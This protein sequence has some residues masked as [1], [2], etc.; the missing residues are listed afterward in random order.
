MEADVKAPVVNI[1][2]IRPKPGRLEAFMA[3]QLDQHR[4]VRGKVAGLRGAR[5][6]RSEQG[7]VLISVFD[8]AEQADAF[9]RDPMF[10]DHIARVRPLIETSE[11]GAFTEAY[12][13]GEI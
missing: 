3:L 12:A 7:V 5:L 13:V 2:V 9:R 1:S 10:T 11:V 6:F 8:S 4:R